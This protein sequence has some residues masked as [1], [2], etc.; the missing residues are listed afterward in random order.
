MTFSGFVTLEASLSPVCQRLGT[1]GTG[2]WLR[3]VQGPSS[4]DWRNLQEHHQEAGRWRQG[5]G[6][7]E[8]KSSGDRMRSRQGCG[9]T[10]FV[11]HSFSKH[12]PSRHCVPDLGLALGSR[13]N[14]AWLLPSKNSQ[15]PKW[16]AGSTF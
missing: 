9:V 7:C 15:S 12:S 1:A 13:M 10:G 11:I 8:L 6:I 2:P 16:L 4:W 3:L 14:Q 5:E